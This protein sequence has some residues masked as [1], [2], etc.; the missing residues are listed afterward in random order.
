MPESLR[1]KFADIRIKHDASH[2]SIGK[3]RSGFEDITDPREIPGAIHP[4]L[5][6]HEE[7]GRQA[8]YLG[9]G[10]FAYIEG[11]EPEASEALLDELW[12]YASL[13]QN[14]WTQEWNVGDVII[15]DNRRVLHRR[16]AFPNHMR[17]MM[18]CCQVL[19]REA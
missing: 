12:R 5:R 8:L 15:W 7:N 10:E 14:V 1:K 4:A 19:A 16:D 9:R 17:R 3:L 13:P 11:M 6:R 18:R 2:T